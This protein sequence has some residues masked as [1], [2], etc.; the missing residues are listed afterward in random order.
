MSTTAED[1]KK[2]LGMPTAATLPDDDVVLEVGEAI[3][4]PVEGTPLDAFLGTLG[5]DTAAEPAKRDFTDYSDE[6][7]ETDLRSTA[8]RSAANVNADL[9]DIAGNIYHSPVAGLEYLGGALV[10]DVGELTGAYNYEDPYKDNRFTTNTPSIFFNR[11]AELNEL[12]PLGTDE[13]GKRLKKAAAEMFPQDIPIGAAG[14]NH[15]TLTTASSIGAE[16]FNPLTPI[17]GLANAVRGP[18]MGTAFGVYGDENYGETG[19]LVGTIGGDLF[20]VGFLRNPKHVF[21]AASGLKSWFKDVGRSVKNMVNGGESSAAVA[22]ATAADVSKAMN[23][24]A[25]RITL[26]KEISNI[27]DPI[28]KA[29]AVDKF[30]EEFMDEIKKL[31]L[32]GENIGDI[33]QITRNPGLIGLVDE[34]SEKV[35]AAAKTNTASPRSTKTY[36][37]HQDIKQ[38]ISDTTEAAILAEAKGGNA[39]NA[40]NAPKPGLAQAKEE[41]IQATKVGSEGVVESAEEGLKITK[42]AAAARAEKDALA[43]FND[44]T[45]PGYKITDTGE[46]GLHQLKEI[47]DNAYDLAWSTGGKQ[48]SQAAKDAITSI[49]AQLD[50]I[51]IGGTTALA[52]VKKNIEKLA[53]SAD[54]AVLKELDETLRRQLKSTTITIATRRTIKAARATL[55]TRLSD[56]GREILKQADEAYPKFLALKNTVEEKQAYLND[57][58]FTGS[59]LAGGA[60]KVSKSN[61]PLDANT[62]NKA[63]MADKKLIDDA[64]EELEK[65]K[66]QVDELRKTEIEELK[67]ID[68]SAASKFANKEGNKVDKAVKQ[69][70]NVDR[71]IEALKNVI[72]NAQGSKQGLLDIKRAFILRF[73][74]TVGKENKLT[75]D[76]LEKFQ[77]LKEVL[78]KGGVLSPEEAVRIEKNLVENQKNW[79]GH[80]NK[81]RAAQQ[82]EHQVSQVLAGLVGAKIGA[83][84][85]GS[86][87]I[88]A[89]YGRRIT[90]KMFD[91]A[92]VER[93]NDLTYELVVNPK[94]FAAEV[95]KLKNVPANQQE[96]DKILYEMLLKVGTTGTTVGVGSAYRQEN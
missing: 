21:D 59:Q 36:N 77:E 52:K 71:P 28:D 64:A 78:V 55:R 32:N 70:L 75:K 90:S 48:T 26:P 84:A 96:F 40:V 27:A 74:N 46:A 5:V 94:L 20:G 66:N 3:E 79:L 35:A 33:A 22:T 11:S 13:G 25:S 7:K 56:E 89:A 69:V 53:D 86:P 93:I 6:E 12:S 30:M 24:I 87:L 82:G 54:G 81:I 45:L 4:P 91:K 50:S 95:K 37:K 43:T 42:A 19:K 92:T 63:D 76:G 85:F 51:G 16:F 2:L 57:G 58:A 47:S 83:F 44:A 65:A 14:P 72:K 18:L 17:A 1:F 8:I 31:L 68:K 49:S 23:Q 80:D 29:K 67:V 34:L 39:A 10:E 88:G 15:N 41:I 38:E 61:R 62:M 9:V 60:G 73:Q